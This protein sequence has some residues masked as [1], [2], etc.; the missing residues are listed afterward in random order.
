[1]EVRVASAEDLFQVYTALH[2]DVKTYV[3]DI[4]PLKEFKKKHLLQS[5]SIRQSANGRALLVSEI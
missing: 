1:M 2:E 4:R 5:Y 3:L